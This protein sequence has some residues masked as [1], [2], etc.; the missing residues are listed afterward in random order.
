M[1]YMKGSEVDLLSKELC[2][3]LDQL[4]RKKDLYFKVE[5]FSS[6]NFVAGR[7]G[8]TFANKQTLQVP[9]IGMSGG[10]PSCPF[11]Y[12][13][14]QYA[15]CLDSSKIIDKQSILGLQNEVIVTY[16]STN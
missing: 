11:F 3:I 14:P 16:N 5:I 8:K 13:N 15:I 9:Q 4:Q 12:K 1:L 10:A 7:L 2:L 6:Y